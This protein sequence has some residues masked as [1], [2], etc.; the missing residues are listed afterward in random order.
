[1]TNNPIAKYI[2]LGLSIIITAF[3]LGKGL[4]NRNAAEDS[5]AVVGLGTK[6][7]TSDEITW[8]GTYSAKAADAKEAYTIINA[9]REKVK[10]FFISKGFVASEFVFGGVDFSKAYRK[11]EV[12]REDNVVKT[13]DIQDG[14]VATQSITFTSK[15]N[16]ALMQ[17]IETVMN[18]TA[19]L[20]NSGIEFNAAGAQYTYS[21]LPS[22]KHNLIE[23]AT[24]DARERAEK[25]VKTAHG[26]LSK[27][28]EASMG[29]FQITGKNSVEEDSYGGNNDTYNKEKTARIT[30]RLTY[31]LD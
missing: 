31:E 16:P 17:K 19:E 15:K 13:E 12:S 11:I 20:V 10:A 18:Q 2:V 30:V 28:K 26:D 14:Y 22:L 7:F 24:Q 6:D 29:V 1:M 25:I 3:V 8:S 23:K 5:I 21:D 9:D 4:K 27:L